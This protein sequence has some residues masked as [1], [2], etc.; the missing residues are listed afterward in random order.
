MNPP[1]RFALPV[2]AFAIPLAVA[3]C[4]PAP[5]PTDQPPV[6][7]AEQ[8]TEMRDAIREPIDKA[9]AVEDTVK[10]AA[11]AQRKQIDAATE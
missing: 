2:V 6:P 8:H 7:K 3:A 9:K 1:L 4:R 11:E 5:P 10:Q